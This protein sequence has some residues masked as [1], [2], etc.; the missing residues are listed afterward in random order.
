MLAQIVESAQAA[1]EL[2]PDL[3]SR[4]IVQMLLGLISDA[5]YEGLV[6]AGQATPTQVAEAITDVFF[7]GL[8]P[9]EAPLPPILG[10]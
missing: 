3:P 1:G 5:S 8:Q 9:K 4:L 2:R 6:A 10:E 7:T